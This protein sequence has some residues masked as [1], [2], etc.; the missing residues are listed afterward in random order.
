M[1]VVGISHPRTWHIGRRECVVAGVLTTTAAGAAPRNQRL[2]TENVRKILQQI[3]SGQPVDLVDN[4]FCSLNS[5][6]SF[7]YPDAYPKTPP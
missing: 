1:T 3:C 7:K 5:T 4:P 2:D 6:K